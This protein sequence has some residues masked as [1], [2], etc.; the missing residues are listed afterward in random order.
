MGRLCPCPGRCE[1]LGTLTLARLWVGGTC[2]ERVGCLVSSPQW[3]LSGGA[4]GGRFSK[5]G[6][7]SFLP[8]S[9]CEFG[10]A[11][12]LRCHCP[13]VPWS[14]VAVGSFR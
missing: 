10:L 6:S 8:R 7:A 14:Q 12:I 4:V 3:T 1:V 9:V 5:E 11:Q 13:T 2:R